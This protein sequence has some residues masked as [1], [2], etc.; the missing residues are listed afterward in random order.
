MKLSKFLS[1]IFLVCAA[2]FSHGALADDCTWFTTGLQTTNTGIILT[3][4]CKNGT[5][6]AAIKTTTVPYS[7]AV[8]CSINVN[9]AYQNTGSCTA[10]VITKKPIVCPLINIGMSCSSP[11]CAEAFGRTCA[12]KGG[13]THLESGTYKCRTRCN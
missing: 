5:V 9:S 8:T 10:P 11:S 4:A 3:Y 12:S 2:A 7:G 6:D 1:G 13:A